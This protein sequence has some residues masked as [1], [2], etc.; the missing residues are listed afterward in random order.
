MVLRIIVPKVWST[1]GVESHCSF[2]RSAAL[3]ISALPQPVI[4]NLALP[5]PLAQRM[6]EILTAGVS[7][8]AASRETIKAPT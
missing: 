2:Y 4:P 7:K 8:S 6:P 5:E 3:P 1:K